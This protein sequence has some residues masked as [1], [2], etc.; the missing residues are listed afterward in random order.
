MLTRI[1][2]DELKAMIDKFTEIAEAIPVEAAKFF[3][4]QRNDSLFWG[5]TMLP[6]TQYLKKAKCFPSELEAHDYCTSYFINTNNAHRL[7]V[8]DVLDAL[9]HQGKT[10]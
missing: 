2:A 9:Y 8:I 7:K 4:V 1:Q 5:G 3:V 6:W 10:F